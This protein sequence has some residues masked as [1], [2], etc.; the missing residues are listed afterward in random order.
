VTPALLSNMEV[1]WEHEYFVRIFELLGRYVTLAGFD[2]RGMGLSDRPDSA[3]TLE[4][5]ISDIVTVM[6]ALGWEKASLA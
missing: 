6:D 5:R 2:K 1:Q 4:Q 3:P